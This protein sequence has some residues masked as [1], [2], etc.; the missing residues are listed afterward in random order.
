[1]VSFIGQQLIVVAIETNK[2]KAAIN[3]HCLLGLCSE[4][5]AFYIHYV[6]FKPYNNLHA[7]YFADETTKA[8]RGKGKLPKVTDPGGGGVDSSVPSE[9]I[10]ILEGKI[11]SKRFGIS[12]GDDFGF[13]P[14]SKATKPNIN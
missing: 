4:C 1:M 10:K 5:W 12:L 3:N 9:T 6:S 2:P 14:R 11:G 13:D 7:R 8:K